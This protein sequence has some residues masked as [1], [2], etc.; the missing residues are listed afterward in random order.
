MQQCCYL[1]HNVRIGCITLLRRY[2]SLA[3]SRKTNY[4]FTSPSRGTQ[5]ITL[6]V[7]GLLDLKVGLERDQPEFIHNSLN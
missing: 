7:L 6:R 5:A 1:Y 2:V 4:E 3:H